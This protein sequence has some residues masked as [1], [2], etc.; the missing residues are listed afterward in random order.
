MNVKRRLLTPAN[1]ILLELFG[2]NE[3]TLAEF[4]LQHTY[5]ISPARIRDRYE[6]TGSAAWYPRCVRSSNEHHK[7]KH[8]KDLSMWKGQEVRVCDNTK[9]RVAFALFSGLVMAGD[10]DDRVRGI[11][12]RAHMGTRV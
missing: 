11:P 5:F 1:E 4:L 3:K 9:A 12:R 7:G 6:K 10:R 2:K 8:K